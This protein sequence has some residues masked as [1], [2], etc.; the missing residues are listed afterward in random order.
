VLPVVVENK[1]QLMRWGL[2]P[3]WAKEPAIGSKM[4]NARSE[5]AEEKPA[6]G[7]NGALSRLTATTNGKKTGS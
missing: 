3:F 1:L 2:I 5:N 4:I 7:V 6:F